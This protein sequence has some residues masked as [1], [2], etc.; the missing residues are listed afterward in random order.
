M[1]C[2]PPRSTPWAAA[3]RAATGV[4]FVPSG[5]G[6]TSP[7]GRGAAV[8]SG[9]GAGVAPA[10]ALAAVMRPI[11]WPTETVSPASARISVSVPLAG[12]GTSASTLSVEISTIVSSA[13]TASPGCLA[14][15]STVPSE[16]DSPIA[17]I[18]ISIVCA[19]ASAGRLGSASA[20]GSSAVAAPPPL[21][22]AE[23][24]SP[25]RSPAAAPSPGAISA[26]RLPTLTVSPSATWIFTTVPDAGAGTSASTLSVEI[27][28]I[29]SSSATVVALL[30]VPFQDGAVG[31]RLT[32]RRHDDFDRGVDRHLRLRPYRVAGTFPPPGG[33]APRRRSRRCP[34]TGRARRRRRPSSR[35][36]AG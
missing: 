28:T 30:L 19:S 20:G 35:A 1:P 6:A 18:V 12:E 14:H 29:V 31:D 36:R 3:T 21:P 27:S 5:V 32:H 26:S 8:G 24:S 17:G 25:L 11:T 22:R 23:P 4:T 34:R 9:A 16:T 13:S 15:S 33:G 7:A 2:T 10:L